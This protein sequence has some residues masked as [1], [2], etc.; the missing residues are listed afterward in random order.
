MTNARRSILPAENDQP[1]P[2]ILGRHLQWT[3]CLAHVARRRRP[4]LH[5]EPNDEFAVLIEGVSRLPLL[6][7][8]NDASAE[9]RLRV[10]LRSSHA[11]KTVAAVTL[12][13]WAEAGHRNCG[14]GKEDRYAPF[15]ALAQAPAYDFRLRIRRTILRKL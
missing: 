9:K 11:V 3:R 7:S 14:P 10:P 1:P 2:E 8:T 15:G 5:V 6:T 13:A 12:E 4:P